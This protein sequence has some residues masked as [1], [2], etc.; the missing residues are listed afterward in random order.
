MKKKKIVREAMSYI[1]IILF[2]VLFRS[3]ILTP[4]K[5]KGPSMLPT[6]KEKDVLILNKLKKNYKRGDVAVIK[7]KSTNEEIIK[8]IIA[9]PKDTIEIKSG[10]IYINSKKIK[11]TYKKGA[12]G[13]YPLTKLE[14]NE[15]FV[16]GDNRGVSMDSRLIG[17]VTKKE[18][19]GTT[20][21]ILFPIKRI[22]KIK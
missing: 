10:N 2:V 16:L 20:K 19:K 15:Y 9:I 14:D 13:N 5:V 7:R 12:T 21:I 4:V 11:E 22:G 1:L 18:I 6:L 8:R 3:F 17:P